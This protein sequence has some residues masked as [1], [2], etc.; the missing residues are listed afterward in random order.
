[1]QPNLQTKIGPVSLGT[2]Q[3]L[4]TNAVRYDLQRVLTLRTTN[5]HLARQ[6]AL[7]TIQAV[8]RRSGVHTK[9]F[10]LRLTLSAGSDLSVATCGL[11]VV[12][13]SMTG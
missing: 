10:N 4:Q 1:M 9:G 8:A 5:S 11:T 7:A 3:Q 12:S 2:Y 13:F 6:V